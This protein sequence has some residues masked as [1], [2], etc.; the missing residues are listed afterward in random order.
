MVV[1]ALT[2]EGIPAAFHATVG[3]V[4]DPQSAHFATTG[5]PHGKPTSLSLN[6]KQRAFD[7]NRALSASRARRIAICLY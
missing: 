4:A 1:M 7:F 5:L 6:T 2:A 3:T